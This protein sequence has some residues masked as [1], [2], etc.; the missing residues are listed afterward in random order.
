MV[1]HWL[2]GILG[3]IAVGWAA[4]ST[5]RMLHPIPRA[6]P[7]PQPFLPVRTLP[8]VSQDGASFE[9][10]V[11][12]ASDPRGVIVAC[13]GYR[14]NRLQLV[15]IAHGLRQRG[16]TVITFD[17]RGHGT[18]PGR[19]TFGV[20]DVWDVEAI[21]GW[22][23]QQ[24]ALRTLPLG[25]FG[26]SLG[27]AVAIQTAIRTARWRALVTDSTYARLFRVVARVVR[28]EYHLPKVPW[29]WMT[30]AGVQLALRC[31]LSRLDP[32]ALA[33][34]ARMPLL[35]IHGA[36]DQVVPLEEGDALYQDWR[37]PKTRWIAP[38]AEHAGAYGGEPEAYLTRVSAFFDRWLRD[39]PA[40][41]ASPS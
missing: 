11:L 3:V 22:L 41:P 23:D 40:L 24:P 1:S 6:I 35:H 20:Q 7:S 16:Y 29:A 10:W 27:G 36:K 12:E 28:Q 32:A 9:A 5:F 34:R 39:S 15:E 17:L 33:T 25:G 21:L 19:C 2:L 4:R 26:W 37:G 30:W 14:A 31:R 8:L 13:H 18:R 38:H